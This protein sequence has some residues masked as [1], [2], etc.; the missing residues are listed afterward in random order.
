[1]IIQGPTAY[2]SS[3]H[4]SLVSV[5]MKETLRMKKQSPV[6]LGLEGT[7]TVSSKLLFSR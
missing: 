2:C 5:S 3:S 7:L 4:G 1:M 6:V